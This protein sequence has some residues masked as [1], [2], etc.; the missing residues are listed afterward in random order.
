MLF[1]CVLCYFV[2]TCTD[3]EDIEKIMNITELLQ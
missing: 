3:K 2:A 1:S